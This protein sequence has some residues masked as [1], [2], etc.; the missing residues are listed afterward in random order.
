M[1]ITGRN[2]VSYHNLLLL[3]AY[4]SSVSGFFS[5]SV[6]RSI[7]QLSLLNE[8]NAPVSDEPYGFWAEELSLKSFNMDLQSL[9]MEDPWKAQDALE[10]MEELHMQHPESTGTV[11]PDTSCFLTVMEGWLD[12]GNVDAAQAVLDRM[13]YINSTAVEPT[14][15]AYMTMIQAWANDAKDDF[16]CKSAGRAEALMRHMEEQGMNPDVR[17][18]SVV[19]DGWCKRAAI[20]PSAIR[21]AD[22]LLREMESSPDSIPPNVVTY[23]NFLGGL[24][25]CRAKDLATQAENV[26]NRME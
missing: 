20:S 12:A 8:Q 1:R 11:Q 2:R 4:L 15:L 23:T 17:I 16:L 18:W 26:L 9:A 3:V 14:S 22:A 7:G 21:R 5:L 25:R 13:K 6:R 24:A 10:I 19:L